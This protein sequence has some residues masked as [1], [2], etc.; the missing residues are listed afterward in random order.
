M[1]KRLFLFASYDKNGRIDD[2]MVHYI[3]ALSKLGDVVMVADCDFSKSELEKIKPYVIHAAARR[4]QGYDFGSYRRAYE[5]AR[6]NGR[7]NKYDYIYFLNDSVY[8][9]LRDLEPYLVQMETSNNDAFG[10]VCNP[11]ARHPHIQSWFIGCAKSVFS[12][13]WFD[14]FLRSITR[15]ASKGTLIALYEHGFTKYLIDNHLSWGCLYTMQGRGI[16]GRAKTLFK[17][18]MPFI[19]KQTFPRHNGAHGM[20]IDYILCRVSPDVRDTILSAARS[21]WGDEY[22]NWLLTR[23]PIK[24]FIRNTSYFM[25]KLFTGTL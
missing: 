1:T 24:I 6:D 21:T 3:H 11:I 8:G 9:P 4:H 22:I 23:N 14:E 2:A 10:M 17:R 7:I 19:K 25:R 15:Q 20:Q 16:Y 12:A 18:G 13:D 5:W